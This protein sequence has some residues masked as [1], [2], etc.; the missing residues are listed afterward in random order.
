MKPI[1]ECEPYE[2]AGYAHAECVSA[3]SSL[4]MIP[5]PIEDPQ[6]DYLYHQDRWAEHARGHLQAAGRH[7]SAADREYKR[8]RGRL[9]RPILELICNPNVSRKEV[10][11]ELLKLWNS[12]SDV[13]PELF[14]SPE[15]EAE[16]VFNRPEW[17]GVA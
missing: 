7:A 1:T 2:A 9:C 6:G 17:K 16:Q 12:M 11:I 4:A 13:N 10:F 15:E 14:E 8:V 5:E 3:S